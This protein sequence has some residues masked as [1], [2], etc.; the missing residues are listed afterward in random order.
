MHV[1]AYAGYIIRLSEA[2][3]SELRREAAEYTLSGASRSDDR[4]LRARAGS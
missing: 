4:S 2:R 3:T 1:D